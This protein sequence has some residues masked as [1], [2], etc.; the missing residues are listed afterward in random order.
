MKGR[1]VTTTSL[2]DPV[3]LTALFN[4]RGWKHAHLK[5]LWRLIVQ[6]GAAGVGDIPDLPKAVRA[7]LS[8]PQYALTTTT[9]VSDST[10]ADASTTK[11]LIRLQ[12][13]HM[14][15]VWTARG[16]FGDRSCQP[17]ARSLAAVHLPVLCVCFCPCGGPWGCALRATGDQTGFV[18][19]RPRF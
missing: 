17:L 8:G 3:R 15:E 1:D 6:Q 10:C 11:L 5:R 18:A 4:A 13:G 14:I 2:L 9:V 7:E 16:E 19:F 12:D